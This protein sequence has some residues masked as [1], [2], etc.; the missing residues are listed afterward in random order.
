MLLYLVSQAPG[1]VL[2]L[3]AGLQGAGQMQAVVLQSLA[4]QATKLPMHSLHLS[5]KQSEMTSP[6][7]IYYLHVCNC[8]H[9]LT[10]VSHRII[11]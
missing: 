4:S 10:A 11:E 3:Q 9:S 2:G 7:H 6:V 8:C 1:M 5:G